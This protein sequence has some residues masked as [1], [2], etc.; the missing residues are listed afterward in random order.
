M[1]KLALY[2]L[3]TVAAAASVSAWAAPESTV[4][5][6][7]VTAELAALHAAGYRQT[8]EDPHYPARLAEALTKIGSTGAS[9]ADTSGYGM[10]ETATSESG[11]ITADR[12]IYRGR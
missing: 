11:S 1:N 12:P 8:G 10:A 7:G 9:T 3:A 6:A 5:R 2:V 4:T